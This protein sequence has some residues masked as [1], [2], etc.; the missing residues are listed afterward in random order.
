MVKMTKLR[1]L[2]VIYL[3]REYFDG[4]HMDSIVLEQTE[5][6]CQNFIINKFNRQLARYITNKND[7]TNFEFISDWVRKNLAD[8]TDDSQF[9]NLFYDVVIVK[10]NLDQFV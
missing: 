10:N 2:N 1:N 4:E 5:N 6:I 3:S 9:T 7:V 8:Y